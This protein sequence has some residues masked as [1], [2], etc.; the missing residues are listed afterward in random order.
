MAAVPRTMRLALVAAIA[1]PAV[2][3]A[4]QSGTVGG[5][6]VEGGTRQPVTGARVEA[7]A[8]PSRRVAA[9]ATT[10]DD[11]RFTLPRLPA[12]A[13]SLIVTRIGL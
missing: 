12:G 11:G 9:A 4:Q 2:A 6:V 8:M 1:A 5:Q 3:S 10:N 7:I 13:Y